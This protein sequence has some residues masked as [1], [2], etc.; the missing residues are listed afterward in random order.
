MKIKQIINFILSK[1][2]YIHLRMV[3]SIFIAYIVVQ[4]VF[5]NTVAD[6][7]QATKNDAG[8]L[9]WVSSTVKEAKETANLVDKI[10]KS[11][12]ISDVSI[13][14]KSGK[15]SDKDGYKSTNIVLKREDSLHNVLLLKQLLPVCGSNVVANI[16]ARDAKGDNFFDDDINFKLGD[17]SLPIGMNLGMHKIRSG[18]RYDLIIPGGEIYFM[19]EPDAKKVGL[20]PTHSTKFATYEVNVRSIDKAFLVDSFEPRIFKTV[21]G[22]GLDIICGSSVDVDIKISGLDNTVLN[23]GQFVLDIGKNEIPYGLEHILM[24]LKEGDVATV[25][26]NKHWMEVSKEVKSRITIPQKKDYL[27]FDIVVKNVKHPPEMFFAVKPELA[28]LEKINKTQR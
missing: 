7:I 22:K 5:I 4:Y 20:K 15:D 23:N 26:L 21:N 27:L 6:K 11:T 8:F 25:I 17:F 10:V 24:H 16:K 2:K 3:I 19:N 14:Y 28:I 9:S 12:G 1:A 18:F 13:N